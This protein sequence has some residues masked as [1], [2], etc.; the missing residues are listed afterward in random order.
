MT[1]TLFPDITTRAER[2][3]AKRRPTP[4]FIYQSMGAG[5]QSTTIALLAAN[6]EIEKPQYA[7]FADTKW[8]PPHVYTHLDALNT[9]I[10]APAGIQLIKVSMG[11]LRR[12]T[13]DIDYTRRI[14]VFTVNPTTGDRGFTKRQCTSYYKLT[15]IFRWLRKTLG[16]PETFTECRYCAGRGHRHVPWLVK[17]KHARTWGVC[18]VCRGAGITTTIGRPPASVWARGMIG[19]S[20]DELGRIG[21][22]E[23]PYTVNEYPLI[24]LRMTREDCLAYC[25]EHGWPDVQKS[26]CTGCPYHTNAEWRRVKADP[27]QWAD[28]VQ[29]DNAIRSRPMQDD[30]A[31]LHHSGK[32]LELADISGGG[33]DELGSCSPYGCRSGDPITIPA[34]DD[35]EWALF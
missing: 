32:P 23:A 5:V 27:K 7:V 28:V 20:V 1:D 11:D 16:A 13:T 17:S 24:D 21:A 12:E 2:R 31:Y 9:R 4:E 14:P 33:D 3:A 22:S 35:D 8:E 29:V 19:F 6:G 30:L 18:S 34:F 10:L 25:A 15:P 26:A